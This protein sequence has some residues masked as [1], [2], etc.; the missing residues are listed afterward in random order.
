MR[1]IVIE[2]T[3]LGAYLMLCKENMHIIAFGKKKTIE[4][5][6]LLGT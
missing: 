5:L 3:L 2:S 4:E 1:E 6:M